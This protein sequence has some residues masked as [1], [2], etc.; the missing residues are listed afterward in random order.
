[1]FLAIEGLDAS[2]KNTVSLELVSYL[3]S[4]RYRACHI[5]KNSCDFGDLDE[6][7]LRVIRNFHDTIYNQDP[8]EYYNQY[9]KTFWVTTQASWFNLVYSFGVRPRVSDSIVVS[10]GWFYKFLAKYARKMQ[11]IDWILDVFEAIP[12][13]DVTVFLDVSPSVT[14]TRRD[15]FTKTETGHLDGYVGDMST[16]FVAYQKELLTILKGHGRGR[17][18]SIFISDL[19]PAA[20]TVSEI[21]A[22]IY[23]AIAGCLE[24]YQ[25]GP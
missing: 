11:E 18:G 4:L 14:V 8:Q 15:S 5:D 10:A 9:E 6:N 12:E 2:G 22:A 20:S 23:G 7:T 25:T 13:P 16:T 3:Q 17:N 21:V 1:M 24:E 19:C